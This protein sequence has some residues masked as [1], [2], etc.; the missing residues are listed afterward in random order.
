MLEFIWLDSNAAIALCFGGCG[1]LKKVSARHL[2]LRNNR[3]GVD[4][5][6]A[7]DSKRKRGS[8]ECQ[9]EHRHEL[10]SKSAGAMLFAQSRV[11]AC[12]LKCALQRGIL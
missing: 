12:W 7:C 4:L 9:A 5:R 2:E 1:R 8:D 3:L 11:H 10:F 6:I